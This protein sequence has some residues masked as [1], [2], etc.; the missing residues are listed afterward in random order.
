MFR[1]ETFGKYRVSSLY[2]CHWRN[3]IIAESRRQ[4]EIPDNLLLDLESFRAAECGGINKLFYRY[5]CHK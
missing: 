4:E 2:T 5:V 1:Y 3:I